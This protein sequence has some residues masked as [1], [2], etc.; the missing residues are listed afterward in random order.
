[1]KPPARRAITRP[2]PRSCVVCLLLVMACGGSDVDADETCD[3][4][5]EAIEE[6]ID[7]M[8]WG[9]LPEVP[10]GCSRSLSLCDAECYLRDPQ[11]T[12]DFILD[13][14]RIGDEAKEAVRDCVDGC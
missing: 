3:R 14:E 13:P 11:A 1:M 2:M 7:T 8:G 12:C 10:P 6:C 9:S 5:V 4:A